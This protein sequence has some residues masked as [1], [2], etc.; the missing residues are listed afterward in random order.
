[1]S[2]VLEIPVDAIEPPP[3]LGAKI[4]TD[5]I[6]GMGKI[7]DQFVII[8]NVDKVLSMDELGMLNQSA[9]LESIT[10]L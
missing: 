1:V 9:E 4:R 3:M 2:A 5:F 10:N 6:E 7:D 8:L